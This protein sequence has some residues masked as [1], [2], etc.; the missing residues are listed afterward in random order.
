MSGL[1]KATLQEIGADPQGTPLGDP[2][3][4]QFNP[5]SLRLQLSNQTEGGESRGRQKR[6][7]L[8]SSSTS[9]S[10]ELVFDTADEGTTEQPR[11]VREKTGV[12][13]K[14]V[15]PRGQGEDKEAP[16]RV[17][18]HWGD[19][20][21]DGVIES[22]NI[23]FDHFAPS[24]VPLRAKMAVEIKEQDAR[25]E[26]LQSGPGANQGGGAPPPGGAGGGGSP[27]RSAL[28][29]GGESAAAFAARVGLDPSAWRG[30]GLGLEASL[31]LQ[32][33][34]EIGFDASLSGGLGLGLTAGAQ[35]GASAS[36]EASFGLE[37]GTGAGAGVR[38]APG[39]KP[40]AEASAGLALAAAGGVAAAVGAVKGARA[41]TAVADTLRAFGLGGAG[42]APGAGAVGSGGTGTGAASSGGTGAAPGAAAALAAAGVPQVAPA[43][44]AAKPARP[45]QP[46]T[47]LA[48]GAGAAGSGAVGQAAPA[49]RPPAADPRA[50]SFGFGVPLRPRV[51]PGADPEGGGVGGAITLGPDR[52][53]AAAPVSRDPTAPPWERLGADPSRS[54]ADEAQRARV[55]GCRC[56][57][58]GPRTRTKGGS[59]CQCTS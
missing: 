3:P 46:R 39:G 41:E 20:I 50:T 16:P 23:D 12:L 8:G 14:F 4:V 58:S 21:L 33:G 48:R 54:A 17:R 19:I 30:L 53:G 24:G 37:A 42:A 25:Y 55:P 56:G 5:N 52:R 59:S 34:L 2:I 38:A 44:P 43:R 47:P 1:V 27:N 15:L 31:S 18:F 32:A 10:L 13:E 11:S 35:V 36:L 45:E 51:R 6:Q 40:S 57:C 28:A 9:L 7:F 29:L 26:F 49:P 22:L